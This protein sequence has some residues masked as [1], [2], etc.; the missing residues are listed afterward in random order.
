LPEGFRPFAVCGGESRE[1]P[2]APRE[3]ATPPHLRSPRP[4]KAALDRGLAAERPRPRRGGQASYEAR[5]ADP[6]TGTKRRG[7]AGACGPCCRRVAEAA[8]PRLSAARG[9]GWLKSESHTTGAPR[10]M[11]GQAA[12]EARANVWNGLTGDPRI[13]I[14]PFLFL[15]GRSFRANGALDDTA[16]GGRAAGKR[17]KE[18][19]RGHQADDS[20]YSLRGV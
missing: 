12:A 20:A 1:K 8:P 18:P 2:R 11:L 5:T 15:A 14:G 17:G 9:N 13:P 3:K 6:R 10:G 16:R 7:N 19:P 4:R